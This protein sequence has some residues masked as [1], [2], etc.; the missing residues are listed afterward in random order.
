MIAVIQCAASKRKGAGHLKTKSGKPVVFVADPLVAPASDLY[1]YVRPDDLSDTNM[2]WRQVL[3]DYNRDYGNNPL[4]LLPASEFYKNPV[5][6]RVTT[7]FGAENTYI[8]SAGW[9]L[10]SARFLIPYYDI[11]FS[12]SASKEPY[13]RR[14]PSDDYMDLNLLEQDTQKP[15]VFFGGKD[16]IPLFCKLTK[17]VNGPRILFYSSIIPPS[18]PGCLIQ[19]FNTSTRTNWHYACANAFLEGE[20]DL[21]PTVHHALFS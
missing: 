18:A 15:I 14:K 21:S 13:K 16:Y 9:G 2:S 19:S 1:T 12:Q 4:N 11:T 6:R 3:L 8:L 10:I 17:G 5:Y 7:K 20:I